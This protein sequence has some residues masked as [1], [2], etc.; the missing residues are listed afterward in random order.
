MLEVLA[1]RSSTPLL[2]LRTAAEI[3]AKVQ[4]L[5]GGPDQLP[6]LIAMV[7]RDDRG[8]EDPQHDLVVVLVNAAPGAQ[9]LP[10]PALA[11][12]RLSLHPVHLMSPDA[13]ARTARF[14]RATGT[15]V[16]PGRT[17]VVFWSRRGDHDRN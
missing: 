17:A 15:F 11:G 9:A 4:F 3:N 2:R 1:I 13:V 5:N 14:D 8:E 6:G 7:V 12:Q 16:I 10:A